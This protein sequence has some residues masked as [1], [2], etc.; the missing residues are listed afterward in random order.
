MKSPEDEV[1]LSQTLMFTILVMGI[2]GYV[3][4]E[5]T[6]ENNNRAALYENG[7]RT[8]ETT[9]MISGNASRRYVRQQITALFKENGQFDVSP[10]YNF[11]LENPDFHPEDALAP[12]GSASA[13]V[14]GVMLP[15]PKDPYLGADI[16][17]LF[18]V[19]P[20]TYLQ[21]LLAH[22]IDEHGN[23]CAYPQSD[24]QNNRFAIK[25]LTNSANKGFLKQCQDSD[26]HALVI[27]VTFGKVDP[28]TNIRPVKVN[29]Q[30]T[31]IQAKAIQVP[32]NTETVSSGI[33]ED[34]LLK[35]MKKW[36]NNR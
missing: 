1:H 8:Y 23:W 29:G 4:L 20:E 21:K 16:N 24:W 7:S 15:A 35:Y 31:P 18:K 27:S 33:E 13:Q 5:K 9:L 28:E 26:F 10:V 30:I 36:E 25:Y 34:P 22:I 12:D 6:I 17:E 32:P 3:L 2:P 14:M 19:D 11:L